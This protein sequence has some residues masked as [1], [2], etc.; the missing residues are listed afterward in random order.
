[1]T[2]VRRFWPLLT[3]THRYEKT[4]STRGRGAGV[5]IE[6][7][8][9]AYLI[10]TANGRI[11]YD[12]GCDY[13]KIADAKQRARYYENEAFPFGAPQMS[14]EQRVVNRLAQLGLKQSEVDLVFVG[15]LHF[16]H[17]GALC[18]FCHAEIHVHADELAAARE[19]ADE[20]YFQ[21]DFAGDYR[22]REQRGEYDLASGVRA[23]ETPGHTAG[24]MSLYVELPKGSP[25]L[26]CGD[27]ADLTENLEDEVAP[28]LCWRERDDIALASIRKLKRIGAET[29][30]RLWPNHDMSFYRSCKPFPQHY[31]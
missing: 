29:G 24:H 31:D 2:Q 23:I 30:A 3:G 19:P 22:W 14:E 5:Y 28:G 21:E 8:I 10:E 17:G 9:L 11:L 26:I 1:M 18:D 16:D 15:H 25:I 20:A 6:A 7:P 27:A 13:A 12:V 4:L